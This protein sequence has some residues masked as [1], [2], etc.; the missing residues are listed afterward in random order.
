MSMSHD[1]ATSPRPSPTFSSKF[2]AKYDV[3]GKIGEGGFGAAYEVRDRS[4]N[5]VWC[6]KIIPFNAS[7]TNEVRLECLDVFI[8]NQGCKYRCKR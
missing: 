8:L 1:S 6:A 2:L 3:L 7:S 5:A 4:T